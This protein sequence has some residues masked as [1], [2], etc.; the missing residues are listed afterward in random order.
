MS[1][2]KNTKYK[3]AAEK[4]ASNIEFLETNTNNNKYK[5]MNN[6]NI[7]NKIN[8]LGEEY[9]IENK[10]SN[11]N[12]EKKI[13]NQIKLC[14]TNTKNDDFYKTAFT[15]REN[16]IKANNRNES[17]NKDMN[18]N[19]N[20]LINEEAVIPFKNNNCLNLKQLIL[21]NI[22]KIKFK[23]NTNN[24]NPNS[25]IEN[26]DMDSHMKSEEKYLMT[27]EHIINNCASVNFINGANKKKNFTF[28]EQDLNN[29]TNEK[30]EIIF[31]KENFILE[32]NKN[33]RNSKN[34]EDYKNFLINDKLK[35]KK[36][37]SAVLKNQ[38]D[39]N[40]YLESNFCPI[41]SKNFEKEKKRL[42]KNVVFSANPLK[43]N[44]FNKSKNS[45]IE[46]NTTN[47]QQ[48]VLNNN[49]KENLYEDV[50][51]IQEENRLIPRKFK[52]ANNPDKRKANLISA[53]KTKEEII[54][55]NNKN[56]NYKLLFYNS[57]EKNFISNIKQNNRPQSQDNKNFV[58]L[59]NLNNKL[60]I[61]N[62][63]NVEKDFTNKRCIFTPDVNQRSNVN[64]NKSEA[65]F[66]QNFPARN[67]L[68]IKSDENFIN[69]NKSWNI[70]NSDLYYKS[71]KK[72]QVFQNVKDHKIALQ[73]KN[74]SHNLELNNVGAKYQLSSQDNEN[75]I[76]SKDE[77]NSFFRIKNEQII[78]SKRNS[79]EHSVLNE[80]GDKENS[81][82]NNII[83][84]KTH[85]NKKIYNNNNEINKQQLV[86]LLANNNINTNM[87]III[88]NNKDNNN[89]NNISIK[90]REELSPKKSENKENNNFDPIEK[91]LN[92]S[93]ISSENKDKDENAK[94]DEAHLK[95]SKNLF[96][97][98]TKSNFDKNEAL[99]VKENL[100]F[101]AGNK[102]N[103]NE[104]KQKHKHSNSRP[105]IF[106]SS[107]PKIVSNKSASNFFSKNK[108]FLYIK[109]NK[110]KNTL[111]SINGE[112]MKFT[113][114][115]N[116]K[117]V[118]FVFDGKTNKDKIPD[119]FNN[120]VIN[121]T[122][123][124]LKNKK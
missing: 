63:K 107:V 86:D 70:K 28:T 54:L 66:H 97:Y 96:N 75:D 21:R 44:Y 3:A 14:N 64:S 23:I 11:N 57:G 122:T 43:R 95:S 87:E 35:L 32:E 27:N 18:F 61:L 91:E 45:S 20:D 115:F 117:K 77:F 98:K 9:T 37:F 41:I 92:F 101:N 55:K 1:S 48:Q 121:K 31:N 38:E 46:K 118:Q 15:N 120:K 119:L 105:N 26:I 106:N 42:N 53:N 112:N 8:I 22:D 51:N 6:F 34:R 33:C 99:I 30:K 116:V 52:T 124:T 7:F 82:L 83:V 85:S 40:K 76:I 114:S 68:K 113:D 56:N 108:I 69:K 13:F 25:L 19:I 12:L 24:D 49:Y 74:L 80:K 88:D 72:I 39:L 111:H 94:D 60:S 59:T 109:D 100:N 103:L 102:V 73:N 17:E 5:S 10:N 47:K 89:N 50:K 110:F 58:F 62:K 36:N 4:N 2:R 90:K 93:R 81:F 84:S 71:K 78:Y 79:N 29:M 65:N 104:N 123:G 67:I 16:R